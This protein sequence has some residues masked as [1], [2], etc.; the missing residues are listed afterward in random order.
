MIKPE[1]DLISV[2]LNLKPISVPAAAGER[3]GWGYAAYTQILALI[4]QWDA[5]LA[6]DL[7]EDQNPLPLTISNLIGRFKQGLPDPQQTYQLR[8]TAYSP[9]TVA[10]FTAALS[11][12]GSLTAGQT[13]EIDH[14]PFKIEAILSDPQESPWVSTESYRHLSENTLMGSNPPKYITLQFSSPTIFKSGGQLLPFPL[15]KLVFGN[16]LEKWNRYAPLVLPEELRQYAL[17][18]L[19]VSRYEL[20]SRTAFIPHTGLRPGAVGVVSYGT[21]NYDRYWMG[22][23]HALARFAFYSGV[24]KHTSM[25]LGQ[26]AA[27]VFSQKKK[28]FREV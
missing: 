1:N 16:L 19:L 28:P 2:I 27:G 11:G 5:A 9:Q 7:H 24:G 18:C 20:H 14:L 8:L 13:L 26:T 6:K 3:Q 10:F 4:Q 25:G 12:G 15:P 21:S 22:L 23:V 17:K